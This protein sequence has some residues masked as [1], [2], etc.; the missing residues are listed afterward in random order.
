MNT[1]RTSIGRSRALLLFVVAL[2]Y[3]FLARVVAAHAAM[4]LASG[5]M[6]REVVNR[7]AYIF[8]LVVGFAALGRS[9][10]RGQSA[11]AGM[12]LVRRAGAGREF[13]TGASTG[14]ALMIAAV[15]PS[16]FIGGL[17]VTFWTAAHQWALLG[18]DLLVLLLASLGEELI[19]RGFPFQQLIDAVG[20][21][22]ATLFMSAIFTAA[23]WNPEAPHPAMLVTF[24][25]SVLLSMAYLRTRALW[26]PWGFH[27]AWNA[28]MGLLFGLPISGYTNF[29]P[30]VQT[31]ALGSLGWTGGDF[32]PEGAGWTLLVVLCGLIV[33]QRVTREY[34]RLYTEPVIVPG[35]IPVDMDA[36]ARRQ[37]E[38]AMG[39]AAPPASEP[40]LVQIGGVVATPGE[41]VRPEAPDAGATG[42]ERETD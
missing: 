17:V 1:P 23:H 16:V 11:L 19:F 38:A 9:T 14:W 42:G 12:G 13:A 2:V 10:R 18:L 35:G 7:A 29:S 4:G 40:R 30:V 5:S 21:G 6:W 36:I 28:S 26:V 39:N 34:A 8:L 37:H 41:P 33:I 27:F 20:P 31:Y 32:G 24:L 15:L 25:L 3:A 22:F